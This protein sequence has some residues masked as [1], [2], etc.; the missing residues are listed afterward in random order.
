[1]LDCMMLLEGVLGRRLRVVRV[2]LAPLRWIGRMV[3]PFNQTLDAVLEIVEF[4]ERKGLRADRSFLSEYPV[5]LTP[6]NSFLR[7]QLGQG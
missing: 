7:E 2:P 6:F 3:R 4:V 5:T 1:M